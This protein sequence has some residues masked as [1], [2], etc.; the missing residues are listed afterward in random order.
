MKNCF[1]LKREDETLDSFYHGRILVLQKRKG[2]RFSVD[3]P[4]LADFI[5]TRE[6]EELLEIGGGCGII[7]LLLSLKPWKHITCLEIQPS[8]ADLARRNV[9]LNQLEGKITVVEADIRDY[10]PGKK[11]D[12]IF[13]NPP[14]F[15]LRS[16]W[17]GRCEERALARHEISV[18]ASEVMEKMVEWL[19]PEGR[20]YLIYPINRYKEIMELLARH[21]LKT[22]RLRLVFSKVDRPPRFFLVE[23]GRLEK[24]MMAMPPLILFEPEGHYTEEAKRIFA[25]PEAGLTGNAKRGESRA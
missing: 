13:S 20:G 24:P 11:F 14:Y 25:G 9:A 4:I 6:G 15:R 23:A 17:L 21:G 18:R 12:V 5:E 3:A 10:R 7:S 2:Y 1:R 22:W 8:L 19:K 16:G